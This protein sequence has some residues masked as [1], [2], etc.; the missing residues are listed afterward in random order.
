MKGLSPE[1]FKSS[2][3]PS[4]LV[5]WC[6]QPGSYRPQIHLPSPVI[7]GAIFVGLAVPGGI[8]V[9]GVA[10]VIL[11]SLFL[12]LPMFSKGVTSD[13]RL[14]ITNR[15]LLVF[16]RKNQLLRAS[17]LKDAQIDME[18]KE[19]FIVT[20][21][22]GDG[23]MIKWPCWCSEHPELLALELEKLGVLKVQSRAA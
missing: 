4:E 19:F 14:V 21:N 3:L 13:V 10:V 5:L 15:R 6:G 20:E 23:K 18:R 9:R 11:S 17:E 8:V 12:V 22:V 7:L 16:N 1:Q 2:L